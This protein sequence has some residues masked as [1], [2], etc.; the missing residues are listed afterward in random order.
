MLRPLLEHHPAWRR[1]LERRIAARAF[2]KV[3]LL[4]RLEPASTW[5]TSMDF[6][7]AT[8]A[9]LERNYRLARRASVYW[10][11]VPR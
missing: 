7:R 6:G 8:A 10:V 4:H 11:Y 2:D 9:A 5:Y 1:A 3:V